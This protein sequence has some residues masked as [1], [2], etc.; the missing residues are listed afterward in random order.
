M[1]NADDQLRYP[2]GKFAPKAE[3]T[4]SDL[5]A[6]IKRIETVPSKIE[7]IF[8]S[9]SAKQLETPYREGGWTARQMALAFHH[10]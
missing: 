6:C 8:K 4:S 1:S 5:E 9:L 7:D 3:Y 2:I 10:D